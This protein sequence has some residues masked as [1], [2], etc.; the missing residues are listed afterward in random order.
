MFRRW[1]PAAGKPCLYVDGNI[2][3][4]EVTASTAAL[5]F[6]RTLLSG[7]GTDDEITDIVDENTFYIIPVVSP[8]GVEHV[9][10]NAGWVRSGTR[11]ES[12]LFLR[13]VLYL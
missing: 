13:S 7:Y 5:Y 3:G 12:V 2:H 1:G 6:A 11:M 9:L 10:S 4:S 8:D